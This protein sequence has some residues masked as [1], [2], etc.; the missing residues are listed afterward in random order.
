M[1]KT[2]PSLIEHIFHIIFIKKMIYIP[3]YTGGFCH[4][5]NRTGIIATTIAII[6]LKNE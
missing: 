1:A 2:I 3:E 6:F 4:Y 5:L